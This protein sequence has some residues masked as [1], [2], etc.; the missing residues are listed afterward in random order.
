MALNPAWKP[1]DILSI[2]IFQLTDMSVER[3][4]KWIKSTN[5]SVKNREFRA[6]FTKYGRK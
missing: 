6:D 5:V 4:K 1:H 2:E 3:R